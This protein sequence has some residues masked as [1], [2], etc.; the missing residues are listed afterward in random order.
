MLNQES[1]YYSILGTSLLDDLSIHI[2]RLEKMA[3]DHVCDQSVNHGMKINLG[4]LGDGE[5]PIVQ[6]WISKCPMK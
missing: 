5:A 2:Y 1:M 4:E 6:K 3:L